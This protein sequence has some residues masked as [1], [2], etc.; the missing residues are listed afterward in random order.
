M[1]HI[2]IRSI[3]LS[4]D[5]TYTDEGLV[6][7]PPSLETREL[8]LAPTVERE[9]NK[10]LLKVA[11]T[12]SKA[13]K[14]YYK[15]PVTVDGISYKMYKRSAS[16][17][18]EG[19]VLFIKKDL[20]ERM[21]KWSNCGLDLSNE[22]NRER[23]SKNYLAYQA[24]KA[25]TLTSC[26]DFFRLNPRNILVIPDLY[27][28]FDEFALSVSDKKPEGET[29][30]LM[31]IKDKIYA[32]ET[33]RTRIRNCIWDGQGFLDE[34]VF[35]YPTLL[36]PENE[37]KYANHSMMIIRNR[38][39]KSC[40]FKTR[41]REWFAD[42]DLVG[43]IERDASGMPVRIN[44]YTEA[45][46]YEEI[47]MVVTYSSLKYLKF[48]A[49]PIDG[50]KKWMHM[51]GEWFG[52]AKVDEQTRYFGG[53]YVRTNYQLLNTIYMSEEETIRF[54]H[55]NKRMIEMISQDSNA[56]LAYNSKSVEDL[57]EEKEI[58]ANRFFE[59][60]FE[61]NGD[62][63]NPRL[64]VCRKL[65][66]LN[67][68]FDNTYFYRVFIRDYVQQLVS[69]IKLGKV[70]V[71]GTY[72]T[73]VSNPYEMLEFIVKK[74]D[75]KDGERG[76]PSMNGELYTTFFAT[77]ERILG[78]RSPHILPGNILV[79][80][81]TY[82]A[83]IQQYFVF[84]PEIVCINSIGSLILHRLNG[85]DQD[86]D[87]ILLT[88]NFYLVEAASRFNSK[89]CNKFTV[90]VNCISEAKE[91]EF[92]RKGRV[93]TDRLARADDKLSNNKIGDIVNTSQKYNSLLWDSFIVDC[94][95]NDE[96]MPSL[97]D[98]YY[99]NSILE[100]LSNNEIDA[101]KGKTDFSSGSVLDELKKKANQIKKDD[102]LFFAF[103]QGK[104]KQTKIDVDAKKK[105]KLAL[106]D[107]STKEM[108]W[109]ERT[110]DK[111]SR[112]VFDETEGEWAYG[113][114]RASKK[115]IGDEGTLLFFRGNRNTFYGR[116]VH[117]EANLDRF[118]DRL[119]RFENVKEALA[120][121]DYSKDKIYLVRGKV[122]AFAHGYTKYE[123]TM[124][125]VYENA[126]IKP[127]GG[128]GL[129][130]TALSDCYKEGEGKSP[131]NNRAK[132]AKALLERLSQ[133][134]EA[135]RIL[136]IS[137]KTPEQ[138]EFL[139]SLDLDEKSTM[140]DFREYLEN[141]AFFDGEDFFASKDRIKSLVRMLD[142]DKQKEKHKGFY[143][144]LYLLFD[145]AEKKGVSEKKYL[146]IFEHDVRK[147][148]IGQEDWERLLFEDEWED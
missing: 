114:G 148:V 68:K 36:N 58:D 24:Y 138:K 51:V 130:Y 30:K 115:E 136:Y 92:I 40:V 3:L 141:C 19:N 61:E 41:L 83:K 123:T 18:R 56:F 133:A 117:E 21:E 144:A 35:D 146:E 73:I 145:C 42:N 71:Q 124:D 100:V 74:F 54:L 65:V 77:G 27:S 110:F 127:A 4:A 131:K 16:S 103:I 63:F 132:E 139:H 57:S 105:G 91:K 87:T 84:N 102:P 28:T 33:P 48:F 94:H 7:L 93:D 140:E 143:L 43:R 76:I 116:F 55:Q 129:R 66:Q 2:W 101:A 79:A 59:S 111:F 23:I 50:I 8:G 6:I 85:S 90:P 118:E 97:S 98:L 121:P 32:A 147:N 128:Q 108:M 72:A 38:F 88:N 95:N 112:L 9:T 137:K 53:K 22:E 134:E 107:N 49:N 47:R 64:S 20:F 46:S 70:L 86:G 12:D 89:I 69:K 80:E 119:I 142:D 52:I 81:N 104:K 37:E 13:R 26:K 11:F 126:A 113:G 31:P 120:Y 29:W 60:S 1:K 106:G 62:Y 34:F 96:R 17:S 122:S 25:L 44:G 5:G 39:F 82:N 99:R 45:G 109:F 14:Q 135:R 15:N 78:S 75:I 10:T 67:P 125:Y